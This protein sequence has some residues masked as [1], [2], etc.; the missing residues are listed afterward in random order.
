MKVKKNVRFNRKRTVEGRVSNNRWIIRIIFLSFIISTVFSFICEVLLKSVD[1]LVAFILLILII[2]IGILFDIIG[3]AVTAADETPFHSMASRKL[4]GARTAVSMIR[5]ASKISNL[6]NDVVGDVCGIIS[7]TVGAAIAVRLLMIMPFKNGLLLSI[8]ISSVI[9]S[10]TVGG[11]ALGKHIA[12]SESN[13]IVYKVGYI[14]E[15][16]KRL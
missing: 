2:L 15:K 11:K 13:N 6:C 14:F 16:F 3:V 1:V 5:N 8:L 7:G 12:I 10:I 9:A 4:L